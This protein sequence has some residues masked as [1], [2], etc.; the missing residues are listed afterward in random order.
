MSFDFNSLNSTAAGGG[1]QGPFIN[2]QARAGEHAPGQNWI[3]RSKGDD[4]ATRIDVISDSFKAGVVF[5]YNTIKLGWEKWAPLGQQNDVQWAPTM[6]L[7]AFPRPTMDKRANEMG[8]ETF[9][10]Q[11]IFAIRVAITPDL[12]GTWNSSQFGSTVAFDAFVDDLKAQGPQHVGKLPLVQWTGAVR[13]DFGGAKVP[14][15]QIADWKDAPAC[16]K[17]DT[18]AAQIQT[19]PAT[20]APAAAPVAAQ[21]APAPA[22]APAAASSI[23]SGAQF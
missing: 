9:L 2:W 18:G 7:E 10:W 8:R 15:L 16:L 6:N 19:G 21:P 13:E 1:L 3:L 5:D 23:P 12:A 11:K 17:Q 22:P 20:P 14:V 4:N